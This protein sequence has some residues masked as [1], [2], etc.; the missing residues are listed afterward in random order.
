MSVRNLPSGVQILP[1]GFDRKLAYPEVFDGSVAREL[2]GSQ[3]GK[4]IV[5]CDAAGCVFVWKCPFDDYL[6]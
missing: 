4:S 1:A 3:T 6:T 5:T 2:E